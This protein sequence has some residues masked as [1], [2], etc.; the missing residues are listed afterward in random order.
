M[1]TPSGLE[2]SNG[3]RVEELTRLYRA[4]RPGESGSGFPENP[5]RAGGVRRS[6]PDGRRLSGRAALGL[7]FC[8]G[9]N[10][11]GGGGSRWPL[12][13]RGDITF[14]LHRFKESREAHLHG[15]AL[16]DAGYLR[17]IFG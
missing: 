15:A 13:N 16:S 17:G 6:G 9:P 7:G 2:P 1:E 8:S 5:G 10:G 14:H 4:G 3:D 11:R 12:G